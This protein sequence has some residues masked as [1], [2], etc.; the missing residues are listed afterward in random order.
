MKS[1]SW[2]CRGLKEIDDQ[3]LA[4]TLAAF[5][6]LLLNL[7]CFTIHFWRTRAWKQ[8]TTYDS[9]PI[10]A[11][12]A[13]TKDELNPE[14]QTMVEIAD[15]QKL[16]KEKD[17][18]C[19]RWFYNL[20]CFIEWIDWNRKQESSA[21]NVNITSWGTLLWG[22][23]YRILLF[24]IW[25]WL[26][27]FTEFVVQLDVFRN[28]FFGILAL[29]LYQLVRVIIL[30]IMF[31]LNDRLPAIKELK[32]FSQFAV[33]FMLYLYYRNIFLAINQW[34]VVIAV[35]V[36]VIITQFL[37]YP[38]QMSYYVYH[39]RFVTL[40]RK[41]EGSGK[42]WR[43][44]LAEAIAPSDVDYEAYLTSL[45]VEYYFDEIATYISIVATFILFPIIRY[46]YNRA[47][48]KLIDTLSDPD[49]KGLMLRYLYLFA[50]E[51]AG[52]I[53]IK[54]ILYFI[55][56]INAP[57]T[58]RNLTVLNYRTRFLFGIFVVWLMTSTYYSMVRLGAIV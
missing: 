4:Y 43:K 10:Q 51:V 30:K 13:A 26:Q 9:L 17:V 45:T 35:S 37:L 20:F 16:F 18:H 58:A 34:W 3:K 42:K 31:A 6:G 27:F 2:P 47:A 56:H 5:Y 1:H 28:S 33:P 19:S 36:I 53:L 57:A 41:I 39:L 12:I 11:D 38:I 52:D 25:A 54:L 21:A 49:F 48:Y 8:P 55:H 29:C 22:F 7:F 50:A 24:G 44:A 15:I 14:D 46:S 32:Y 23:L 40:K